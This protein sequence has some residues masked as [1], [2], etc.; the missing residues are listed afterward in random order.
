MSEII[1]FKKAKRKEKTLKVLAIGNSFSEDATSYIKQIALADNVDLRVANA[2]IG[3]CSFERHADN[4]KNKTTDYR[5]TYYTPKET[6]V[7]SNCSLEQCITAADWDIITIQQVSSLSG[8]YET[9]MPFADELV[10][11]AKS[12][13]P[14]VEIRIHMVWAYAR[15]YPGIV[16]NGYLNQNDMYEKVADAY[17]KLSEHFDGAKILPSGYAMQLARKTQIGDD[18]HRDG[19]HCSELGR[20]LTGWVWFECLTGISALDS[21]FDPKNATPSYMN[22]VDITHEEEALLRRA[23]HQ[24][25]EA[26]K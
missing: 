21:K 20:I 15:F 12:F 1:E 7:F 3:G 23:A 11:Y 17:K 2:F 10:K 16:G 19:F 8:K 24:A 4:I 5:L 25:A 9:Y 6:F 26:Y 14:N 22:Y 18:I 13:H